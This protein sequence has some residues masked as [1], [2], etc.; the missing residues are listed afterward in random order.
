MQQGEVTFSLNDCR[1]DTRHLTLAPSTHFGPATLTLTCTFCELACFGL[2]GSQATGL[3][4]LCSTLPPP[5]SS[6]P[7][8]PTQVL[9]ELLAQSVVSSC[10]SLSKRTRPAVPLH[11]RRGLNQLRRPLL[12][13]QQK[14][15]ADSHSLAPFHLLSFQPLMSPSLCL[16]TQQAWHPLTTLCQKPTFCRWPPS[17][18]SHS[19]FII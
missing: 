15:L 13:L 8:Q 11:P 19:F 2:Q 3:T 5:A 10:H 14:P 6:P 9:P 12:A 18:S 7:I 1:S 17:F 4:G 16:A